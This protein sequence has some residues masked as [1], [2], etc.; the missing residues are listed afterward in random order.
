MA[1]QIKFRYETP[2]P[3]TIHKNKDR[4]IQTQW[5]GSHQESTEGI[6]VSALH[7]TFKESI[8]LHKDESFRSLGVVQWPHN[9]WQPLRYKVQSGG[10]YTKSEE[11]LDSVAFLQESTPNGRSE[12]YSKI[13]RIS[14][15]NTIKWP[16]RWISQLAVRPNED[17]E[18]SNGIIVMK[19]S[20]SSLSNNWPI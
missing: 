9:I 17:R 5:Y 13:K 19:W 1:V 2:Y 18:Q 4:G 7:L 11:D 3:Q 20:I 16:H 8:R 15:W 14:C 6:R 10:S 12:D